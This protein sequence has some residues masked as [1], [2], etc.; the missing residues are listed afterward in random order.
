MTIDW[1][2]VSKIAA[3]LFTAILMVWI[4]GW[5]ESTLARQ[6]KQHALSRLLHDELTEPSTTT[7]ALKRMAESASDGKLRLLSVDISSLIFKFTTELADLDP[8]HAYCYADLAS[9][10]ELVNKGLQRLAALTL[11]RAAAASKEV[12]AQIDRAIV[13]QSKIT[14]Q[15][16]ITA[17]LAALAVIEVIPEK[18]RY[19]ADAQAVASMKKAIPAAEKVCA[20]WPSKAK[21]TPS[22][23]PASSSD[24]QT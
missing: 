4:K 2:D 1:V 15:D 17:C 6:N 12:G 21:V 16:Y 10:M 7:L 24:I 23:S 3:P 18:Y 11:S 13:G 5:I 14:A 19:N 9:A 20:D 22:A 8:K